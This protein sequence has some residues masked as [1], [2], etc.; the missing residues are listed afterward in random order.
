M[1]ARIGGAGAT[2]DSESE[3]GRCHIQRLIMGEMN[4]E[5][6]KELEEQEWHTA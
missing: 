3:F 5:E 6:S 1:I 4:E 2:L